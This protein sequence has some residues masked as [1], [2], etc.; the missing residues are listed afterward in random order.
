MNDLSRFPTP[1]TTL[2]ANLLVMDAVSQGVGE[3]SYSYRNIP[4]SVEEALG[5][6]V[7]AVMAKQAVLSDIYACSSEYWGHFMVVLRDRFAH[8][9]I[10]VRM[11]VR[12]GTMTFSEHDG[13]CTLTVSA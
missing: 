2:I 10:S 12:L 7:G 5:E 4:K 6:Y 1:I 3:H 8:Q 13:V 9:P 11:G